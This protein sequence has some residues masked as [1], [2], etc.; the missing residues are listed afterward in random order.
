MVEHRFHEDPRVHDQVW[1]LERVGWL[2]LA[3]SV[4]LCFA[5]LFGDGPLGRASAGGRGPDQISVE[6]DRFLR[7]HA[8]AQLRIQL[9]ATKSNADL[10]LTLP[11]EYFEAMKVQASA[12]MP[13][14]VSL[15]SERVLYRFRRA[16]SA[17]PTTLTLFLEPGHVGRLS[18]ELRAEP[19]GTVRFWQLVYP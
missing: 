19:G 3:L 6:Y 2:V 17:E 10:E 15:T 9:P 13:L 7:H 1:V 4:V 5:S 16:P 11:R 12:P 14:S 18:A 8:S